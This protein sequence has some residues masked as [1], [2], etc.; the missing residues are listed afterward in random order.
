[1]DRHA[2]GKQHDSQIRLRS[3]VATDPPHLAAPVLVRTSLHAEVVSRWNASELTR[4]AGELLKQIRC[5]I[6]RGPAR[7][8]RT[9]LLAGRRSIAPTACLTAGLAECW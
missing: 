5:A 6:R 2:A 1:M 8:E 7:V 9:L 3:Q 4:D